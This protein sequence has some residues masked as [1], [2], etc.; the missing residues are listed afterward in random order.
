[1]RLLK[2]GSVNDTEST[3]VS[4]QLVH[5]RFD[6]ILILLLNGLT[7]SVCSPA[8]ERPHVFW[9]STAV[10]PIDDHRLTIKHRLFA[11]LP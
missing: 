2:G 7:D 4:K 8:I 1:M 6:L 3:Y 9:L 11:T 5:K 10:V